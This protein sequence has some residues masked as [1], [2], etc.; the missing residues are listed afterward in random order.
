MGRIITIQVDGGRGGDL[1]Q[2][3]RDS[4]P[5]IR[6]NMAILYTSYVTRLR[7]FVLIK[8]LIDASNV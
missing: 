1:N 8:G 2:E 4:E 3:R 7:Q 5:R 6:S